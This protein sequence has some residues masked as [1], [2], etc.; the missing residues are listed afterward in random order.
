MTRRGE[1]DTHA[2]RRQ[3]R[4]HWTKVHSRLLLLAARSRFLMS[5]GRL[6]ASSGH[7]SIIGGRRRLRLPLRDQ[8][9]LTYYLFDLRAG[10]KPNR[11][12]RCRCSTRAIVMT[13][14]A[15]PPMPLVFSAMVGVKP[16]GKHALVPARSHPPTLK[17]A[18]V[19]AAPRRARLGEV[20]SPLVI[21]PPTL[22]NANRVRG[23]PFP[24]DESWKTL[25]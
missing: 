19:R 18:V 8:R 16:K 3:D 9:L 17:C 25:Q 24:G 12:P 11:M 14:N 13:C 7:F 21:G 23:A 2:C 4:D 6:L 5:I 15:L 1:G 20:R 22:E 10:S